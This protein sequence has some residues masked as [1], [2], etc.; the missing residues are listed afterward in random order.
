MNAAE[1]TPAVNRDFNG[2]FSANGL[3][4]LPFCHLFNVTHICRYT[5]VFKCYWHAVVTS[6]LYRSELSSA[7]PHKSVCFQESIQNFEKTVNLIY[8]LKITFRRYRSS[9]YK[10]EV[11]RPPY[12]IMV[13]PTP[14]KMVLILRR[15]LVLVLNNIYTYALW[16]VV[17]NQYFPLWLTDINK[18]RRYLTEVDHT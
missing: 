1:R 8:S 3:Q 2:S 14:G 4:G 5:F 16:S 17:W 15:V 18:I 9:H 7:K 6:V 13:I 12:F 11:V 10:D